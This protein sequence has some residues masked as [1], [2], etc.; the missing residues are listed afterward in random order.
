MQLVCLLL[1]EFYSPHFSLSIEAQ[2]WNPQIYIE[3]FYDWA[4]HCEIDRYVKGVGTSDQ[5]KMFLKK[6]F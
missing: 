1:S 3:A 5:F 6:G 2:A 4:S